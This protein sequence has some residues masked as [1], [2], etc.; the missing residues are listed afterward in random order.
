MGHKSPVSFDTSTA[1]TRAHSNQTHKTYGTE[2]IRHIIIDTIIILLLQY[3]IIYYGNTNGFVHTT[4]VNEM[5]YIIYLTFCSFEMTYTRYVD[6]PRDDTYTFI[7]ILLLYVY[8]TLCSYRP[9]VKRQ[10]FNRKT[11]VFLVKNNDTHTRFMYVIYY[12][13]II[14]LLQR[15]DI[16]R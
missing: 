6:T 5:Q 16:D 11:C 1:V 7:I 10:H 13:M 15:T 12:Y 3:I 2:C 8:G 4:Y 9:A 14:I